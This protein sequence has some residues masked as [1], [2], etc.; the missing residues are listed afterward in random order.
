[1]LSG[2]FA[3]A[4]SKESQDAYVF[5]GI[6]AIADTMNQSTVFG[7][8]RVFFLVNSIWSNSQ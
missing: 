6:N 4:T 1:M 8:S 5:T 7:M 3:T 2:C